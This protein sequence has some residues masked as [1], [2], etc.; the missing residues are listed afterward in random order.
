MASEREPLVSVIMLTMPSRLAMRERALRSIDAQSYQNTDIIL[1]ASREGVSIGEL[2]NEA[3]SRAAGEII[4]HADDDDYQHPMRLAEQ[5]ALLQQSGAEACGYY[6]AP[7]WDT[8]PGAFCGAWLYRDPARKHVLGASLCYTRAA[9]ERHPFDDINN[10]EDARFAARCK[11]VAVSAMKLG[12]LDVDP[13]ICCEVHGANSSP[14]YNF[15]RRQQ[16]FTRAPEFDEFCRGRM[17]L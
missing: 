4:V 14:G 17:A 9:W 3:C 13:R 7:F 8:R 10:G 16:C 2:R 15:S 5:V 6:E 12:A 11:T 1:W